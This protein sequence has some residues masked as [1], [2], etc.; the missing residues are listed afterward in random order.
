M[1]MSAHRQFRSRVPWLAPL[2]LATAM[3]LT[4]RIGWTQEQPAQHDHSQHEHGQTLQ[5]H[6]QHGVQPAKKSTS[7]PKA[8]APAKKKA[9]EKHSGHTLPAS[10]KAGSSKHAGHAALK[11]G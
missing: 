10:G 7:E 11:A 5:D 2:A 9:S 4:F 6:S 8:K 3:I 1:T